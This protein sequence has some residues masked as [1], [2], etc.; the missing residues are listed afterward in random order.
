MP[1]GGCVVFMSSQMG[2]VGAVERTVY[3]ATKHAVEGLVKAMAIELAP[4]GIRVVSV[5]PTFVRTEMTAPQ[6]DDSDIGQRL[7]G[8][9]PLGRPATAAEVA[10]AVTWIAS[11][12]A[13]MTTGCSL[14][15]DGGWT[16]R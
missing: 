3:C 5:A 1:A 7:R 10:D 4:R 8:Q 2:H 11:P 9:I 16:V 15:A 13:A 12:R 14:L 6:L